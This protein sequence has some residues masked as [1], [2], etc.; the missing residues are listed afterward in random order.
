MRHSCS[1]EKGAKHSHGL[2]YSLIYTPNVLDH[3]RSPLEM[4]QMT[5]YKLLA[6]LSRRERPFWPQRFMLKKRI[7]EKALLYIGDDSIGWPV[8]FDSLGGINP[9]A[10]S[11]IFTILTCFKGY[12]L[13]DK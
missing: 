6:A 3:L 4:P 11:N 9:F 10:F 8:A 7:L 12:C 5:P 2:N 1:F 13:Q